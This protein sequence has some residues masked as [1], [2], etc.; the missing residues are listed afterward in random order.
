MK[1]A[2][3]YPWIYLKSGVER[4]ILETVKRSRHQYTIFTNH[5]DKEGTYTEFK[6]LNVIQLKKIPVRRNIF[7]TVEAALVILFQKIDLDG[8]AILIVHS[9]GLGDLILLRNMQIPVVCFCHT[10]LRP[11]FD[12][13]YKKRAR[14]QRTRS[15]KFL[16]SIFDL[17]FKQID[18][19]FWKRY[20]YIF[21]NSKE[22]LNRAMAGK[23]LNK[24]SNYQILH[25]GVDWEKIKPTWKFD[26]Y[27]FVPGRIMWTKNVELA[28]KAFKVFNHRNKNSGFR[29]IIGGQ[30][31]NKSKSYLKWL[32]SLSVKYNNIQFVVN[33]SDH[34][35]QNL[36]KNCYA[37]IVASFNEDWGIVPIEA[38]AHGKAVLAL[39]SGGFKESQIN[40]LT[41]YLIKNEVSKLAEKMYFLSKNK[42][43]TIKMGRAARKNSKKYNWGKFIEILDSKTNEIYKGN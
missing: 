39:N 2:L 29:L 4:T 26:K 19:L 33:P 27:F 6:D 38:N 3:Y 32:K 17:I 13:E 7:S 10:P 14:A 9:D 34:T 36:Y 28:V 23:L 43:Q 18:R 5:Y 11:V 16:Y 37:V 12:L 25:P 21:F 15:R 22:S 31:D 24:L 20:K 30:V 35:I 40:G 8:F 1:I 41:G 42:K